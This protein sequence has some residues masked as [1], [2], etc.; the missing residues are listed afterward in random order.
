MIPDF[1]SSRDFRLLTNV[2]PGDRHSSYVKVRVISYKKPAELFQIIRFKMSDRIRQNIDFL[3]VLAKCNKKQRTALL[4]H[5]DIELILTLSEIAVNVLK[6]VV[7]LTPSQ[8][9]KLNRFKKH[10][11]TLSERQVAIKHKIDF[12]VQK[13]G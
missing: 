1:H 7:K 8:K 12:L 5:C 2:F 6:G 9:A 3:S 11:R 10:L 4:E 13:G